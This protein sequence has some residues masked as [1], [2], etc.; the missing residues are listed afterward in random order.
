MR[1]LWE[2][3]A[4]ALL[5]P[6]RLVLL[7]L[8]A[9]V[10]YDFYFDDHAFFVAPGLL[11]EMTIVSAATLVAGLAAA[12]WVGFTHATLYRLNPPDPNRARP[13]GIFGV[14]RDRLSSGGEALLSFIA[15]AAIVWFGYAHSLPKLLHA[16]AGHTPSSVTMTMNGDYKF[17]GSPI[18]ATATGFVENYGFETICLPE[19]LRD[20]VDGHYGV[21]L[22]LSGE[23]SRY[24]FGV[25]GVN[26]R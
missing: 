9:L 11:S 8:V 26:L 24:G 10:G 14:L 25:K 15:L 18:C 5:W 20:R 21:E 1:E 3:R 17:D 6:T 19:N 22:V 2:Q 4:L 16:M 13:I 7:G 12:G 23:T